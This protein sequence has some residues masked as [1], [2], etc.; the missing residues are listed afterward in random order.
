MRARGGPAAACFRAG[1]GRPCLPAVAWQPVGTRGFGAAGAARAGAPV[2]KEQQRRRRRKAQE[3]ETRNELAA[4]KR[5]TLK[6]RRRLLLAEATSDLMNL[7]DETPALHA[8]QELSLQDGELGELTA[9]FEPD[10]ASEA[11]SPGDVDDFGPA[12]LDLDDR[13]RAVR[14]TPLRQRITAEMSDAIAAEGAAAERHKHR[15]RWTKVSVISKTDKLHR[16]SASPDGEERHCLSL[17]FRGH[18]A[19]RLMPVPALLL[20]QRSRRPS[21]K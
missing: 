13:S 11:W 6:D 16:K 5:S 17:T 1:L 10:E 21:A 4:A 2:T 9:L 18:S 7:T 8:G 19:K 14:G 20:L 15:R 12:P 3:D